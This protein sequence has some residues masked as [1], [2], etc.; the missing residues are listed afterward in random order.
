MD[1]SIFSHLIG[2]GTVKAGLKAVDH[3]IP[4]STTSLVEGIDHMQSSPAYMKHRVDQAQDFW[5]DHKDD[6]S[7]FF[8]NVGD[9]VNN[10][11]EAAGDFLG[12]FFDGIFS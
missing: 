3:L 5:D 10:S 11:I 4:G 8:D 12:D 7:D 6:V 1:I 9:A 2:P